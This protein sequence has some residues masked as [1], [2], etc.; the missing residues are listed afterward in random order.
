MGKKA[1][2]SWKNYFTAFG[3][4]LALFV[5]LLKIGEWL[6]SPYAT[7][8]HDH[9]NATLAASIALAGLIA[10]IPYLLYR[11]YL[12]VCASLLN[13]LQE[14]EQKV[15]KD[16]RFIHDTE[17]L[18]RCLVRLVNESHVRIWATGSRSRDSDYLRAIEEKLEKN[19]DFAY[20]RILF[21]PIRNDLLKNH[22][23]N[24]I[25]VK[26]AQERVHIC[27]IDDTAR[28]YEQFFSLS[29][30]SAL[31]V[32]PS[33]NAIGNHDCAVQLRGKLLQ[34]LE[35]VA[36]SFKRVSTRL[37]SDEQIQAFVANAPLGSVR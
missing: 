14:S 26:G 29:E 22:L 33:I 31:V 19:N 37:T 11:K 12:N 1:T 10:T 25:K 16:V 5:G 8:A 24:V 34:R 4:V 2:W 23:L 18:K 21:G 17:A 27:S 3:V 20:V 30:N 32:L 7:Q 35:H 9:G 6:D 15:S 36:E 28:Y 13:H